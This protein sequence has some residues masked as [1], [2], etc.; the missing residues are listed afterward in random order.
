VKREESQPDASP[1]V[2][3]A[4]RLQEAILKEKEKQNKE[5][6]DCS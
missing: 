3:T 5:E 2:G 4:R 6:I 1:G